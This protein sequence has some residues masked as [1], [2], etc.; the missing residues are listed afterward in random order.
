MGSGG[1]GGGISPAC[2]PLKVDVVWD[3]GVFGR[4]VRDGMGLPPDGGRGERE[5]L[6]PRGMDLFLEGK[7][8]GS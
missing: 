3:D 4:G 8:R 7:M 2:L 5:G 1:R 6:I